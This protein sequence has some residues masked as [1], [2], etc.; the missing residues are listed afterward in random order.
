[1]STCRGNSPIE[2]RVVRTCR[3]LLRFTLSLSG[4]MPFGLLSAGWPESGGE[5]GQMAIIEEYG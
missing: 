2:T 1:M 4:I 3:L 5:A